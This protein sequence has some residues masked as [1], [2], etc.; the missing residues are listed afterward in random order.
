MTLAMLLAGEFSSG[1][2]TF[3]GT[4][5]GPVPDGGSGTPPVYGAPLVISFDVVGVNAPIVDISVAVTLTHTWV[6]D[7]DMRLASPNGTN[8]VLVSRIGVMTATGF[9]DDSNYGG[10]YTFNDAAPTPP[11]I[12]TVATDGS[13][14]DTCTVTPGTYR[15]TEAGDFG[16]INPAPRTQLNLAFAGVT[17][18]NG[19]W[20]LMARD[21]AQ[22]DVGSVTAASLTVHGTLDTNVVTHTGDDGPGSLRYVLAD[23]GPGHVITFASNVIGMITLTNGELVIG[24]SLSIVGPCAKQL[25]ISGNNSNR[26]FHITNGVVNISGLT[27]ANGFATDYGAGIK[28]D[29]GSNTISACAIVGNHAESN[30]FSGGGGIYADS[31][32]YLNVENSTLAGNESGAAGAGIFA[33]AGAV[34]TIRNTTIS[35]NRTVFVGGITTKRGGGIAFGGLGSGILTLI[36]CTV[37][38]NSSTNGGGIDDSGSSYIHV[39]T[40]SIIAGNSGVTGPDLKGT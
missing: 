6:G 40:N 5:V 10:T 26:V 13:C 39:I 27:I 34:L 19:T 33:N 31:D 16:Q 8:L 37:T 20:T 2:R 24:K 35:S 12:W 1:A 17:N 28:M 3:Q 30:G 9:G 29:G 32:V 14:G 23:S 11:H 18:P 15:T 21:A 4:G 7:V 25:T 22:N 38:G 36:N